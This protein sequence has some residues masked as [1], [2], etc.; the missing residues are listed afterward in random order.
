[1]TLEGKKI[2]ILATNGFEQSE[3][4]EPKEALEKAG[5]EVEV[6]S[7]EKGEIKGWSKGDWGKKCSVDKTLDEANAE[8]YDGLLLPGGVINPD[9]LRTEESAV[10]FVQSFVDSRK[11]IAAICH[12]PQILIETGCVAGK[13]MTS[14]PSIKTD[15]R[16]AGANWVDSEVVTDNGLVTSRKP[17]DIPAFNKKMVEEFA[18]GVHSSKP[19]LD[20]LQSS[21][22]LS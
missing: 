19:R 4:F 1:M 17:D 9:K 12:G 16:N 15:L 11:P 14:W 6:V 21:K 5:A 13:T 8:D 3:L 20:N 2:A 7:P 18:E 22:Q 10:Q